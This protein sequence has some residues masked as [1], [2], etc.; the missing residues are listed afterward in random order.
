MK[1]SVTTLLLL[2]L[3]ALAGVATALAQQNDVAVVVNANNATTSI[4][5]GDLRKIFAGEKRSWPGGRP[6]QVI[7]RVPGTPERLVLLKLLG[8]SEKEYTQYWAALVF[9]G[10]VRNEPVAVFSNGMEKEAVSAIPGAIALM[11]ARDVKP[12]IK[13]VKVDGLLPGA[14]GYPLH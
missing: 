9:R 12:G 2:G 6:I 13:V 1:P 4:A 11:E 7:V 5:I 3:A 14:S 8:M 10:D